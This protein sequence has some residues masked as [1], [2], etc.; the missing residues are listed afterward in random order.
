MPKKQ[1]FWD[2][3]V[4]TYYREGVQEAFLA[5]Q[6]Q[7]GVD[8]NMLLFCIWLGRTH[9]EFTDRLFDATCEFSARWARHVVVPL[10]EVRTWMK[11]AGCHDGKVP[12]QD[13]MDLREKV[14]GVEFA[15]EKMQEEALE[16]LCAD[17]PRVQ[18]SAAQQL[19]AASSNVRRYF[20]HLGIKVEGAALEQ[21]NVI[22]AA[23]DF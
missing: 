22:M 23:Q 9:G 12:V 14:K 7:W 6:N 20:A 1:G 11:G 13:C 5:L 19:A 3:S 10:R 15:A 17:H 21:L 4:R 18:Q 8:I 16:S 2:F